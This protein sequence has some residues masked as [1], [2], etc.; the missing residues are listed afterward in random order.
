M[1]DMRE[2]VVLPVD[3]YEQLVQGEHDAELLKKFIADKV[4]NYGSVSREDMK[5]L[6]TL[7]CNKKE[8]E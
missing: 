2:C 1:V 3:R 5:L 7:Y 8:E 4:E 6:Y